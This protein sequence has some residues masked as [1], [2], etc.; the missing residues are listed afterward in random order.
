M[1]DTCFEGV[2]AS[3]MSAKR[4]ESLGDFK[5]PVI[6]TP[7]IGRQNPEP[8][9]LNPRIRVTETPKLTP[10]IKTPNLHYGSLKP[11]ILLTRSSK[12]RS[13]RDGH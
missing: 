1:L 11:R 7:K 10:V 8:W 9:S 4:L 6:K 3:K 2:T 5:A 12:T 13:L